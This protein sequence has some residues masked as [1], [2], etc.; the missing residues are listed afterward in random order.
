MK[1]PRRE[2][3]PMAEKIFPHDD[4]YLD[5]TCSFCGSLD[6]DMLMARLEKGEVSID[7]TDKDYK[8]YVHNKGGEDF[9]RRYRT[10]SKPFISWTSPEHDWKVEKITQAK[11][12]F[13]H[14]S[15]EQRK[16]FVELINEKKLNINYPGH[17][18]RLPFFVR[19]G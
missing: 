4:E 18:Y 12:Y 5:G 10:D 1:C 13:Q 16:R 14:F 7:P 17:F 8:L 19:A 9:T 6:P 3:N 11:F 2:E 15:V